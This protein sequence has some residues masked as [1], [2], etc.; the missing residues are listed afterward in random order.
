MPISEPRTGEG[1]N[2]LPNSDLGDIRKAV[3]RVAD[4]RQRDIMSQSRDIVVGHKRWT[5]N[6]W[7][8]GQVELV[9]DE[10]DLVWRQKQALQQENVA[11]AFYA[12]HCRAAGSI[13]HSGDEAGGERAL[14]VT[15][16]PGLRQVGFSSQGA[17]EQELHELVGCGAGGE[18]LLEVALALDDL[19]PRRVEQVIAQAV[20]P[21]RQLG[22]VQRMPV[23]PVGEPADRGEL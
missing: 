17:V 5:R 21:R 10:L 11:V 6:M 2:I 19:G 20:D 4:A 12:D 7:S 9:T 18:R 8:G 1:A 22:A 3:I 16:N 13:V 14:E 15:G 23:A